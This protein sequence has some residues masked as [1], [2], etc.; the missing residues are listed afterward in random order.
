MK[1][2]IN[3]YQPSCYPIREKV[4]FKQFLLLVGICF[5]SVLVTAL[6]LNNQYATIAAQAQQHKQMVT[7]KQNELAGLVKELQNNRAPDAKI[8]Q[9]RLMQ[10]EVAAK[11]RLLASL[12]GIELEVVVSFSQ[13]MR[14]L[15]L[16][17]QRTITIDKFS[18]KGG[19]L[20]IAGHAKASDSVPLWLSKV[21]KTNEL[22][23]IAFEKL[24]ISDNADGFFF[25]LSNSLG[26]A[27]DEVQAQ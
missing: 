8:H 19:S 4:T 16:A 27:E 1:K 3:L 13:L 2:K 14:G 17:S 6:I 18:I 12:A 22:A 10:D 21:Q 9:Q 23:G 11:Q 26:E 7:I 15:S 20:N 24:N 25:E 5:I